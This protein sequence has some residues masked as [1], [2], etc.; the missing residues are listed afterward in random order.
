MA[1][2]VFIYRLVAVWLFDNNYNKDNKTFEHNYKVYRE[3]ENREK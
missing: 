2:I 1:Y 3:D